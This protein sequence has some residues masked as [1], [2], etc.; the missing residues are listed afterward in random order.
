MPTVGPRKE[1]KALRIDD[2]TKEPMIGENILNHD[3]DEGEVHNPM[4]RVRILTGHDTHRDLAESPVKGGFTFSGSRYSY[5]ASGSS[6]QALNAP[7][8]LN[9]APPRTIRIVRFPKDATEPIFA[10]RQTIDVKTDEHIGDAKLNHIPDFRQD[11]G[12]GESWHLHRKAYRVHVGP[13]DISEIRF[14]GTY[15]V[16]ATYDPSYERSTH[17]IF[18]GEGRHVRKDFF[19]AKIGKYRDANRWTVYVDMPDE[20]LSARTEN[21]VCLWECG[22]ID[23]HNSMIGLLRTW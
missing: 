21:G 18:R 5:N 7:E 10:E 23:V 19:I 12:N 9:C 2:R 8:P 22:L 14:H 6:S 11:W 15:V 1:P 3:L 17:R 16:F 13:E 4:N 20:F